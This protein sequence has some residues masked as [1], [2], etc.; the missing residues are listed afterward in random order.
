MELNGVSTDPK[1]QKTSIRSGEIFIQ[2]EKNAPKKVQIFCQA[3]HCR[4]E[5]I[6]RLKIMGKPIVQRA[7][8]TIGNPAWRSLVP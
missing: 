5:S 4:Y 7:G 8:D 2:S 6:G 3:L 1:L